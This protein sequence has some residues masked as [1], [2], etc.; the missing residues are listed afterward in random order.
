MKRIFLVLGLV[1][2]SSLLFA[3]AL[4]IF[5]VYLVMASQF[6]SLLNPFLILFAVPLA[7]IGVV[8]GL[9]ATGT[10]RA[11]RPLL[12]AHILTMVLAALLALA[13]LRR[14]DWLAA[15]RGTRRWAVAAG[16][17]FLLAAGARGVADLSPPEHRIVNP[18][19]PPLAMAGEGQG[20]TGPFFPSS[21]ETAQSK[22]PSAP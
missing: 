13:A 7:L 11:F 17:L 8:A 4:A 9:L 20:P 5:L 10:T 2:L 15:S 22:A 19:L 6:E 12:Y 16:I 14:P 18:P 3:A 1:L 21:A